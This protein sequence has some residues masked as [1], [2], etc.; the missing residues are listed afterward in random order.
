MERAASG[1]GVWGMVALAEV[2][3]VVGVSG[4]NVGK[5]RSQLDMG[6]SHF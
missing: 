4:G 1:E 5:W 3:V 6:A 2:T